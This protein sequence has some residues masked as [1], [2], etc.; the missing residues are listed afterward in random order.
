MKH[1]EI[2]G[3]KCISSTRLHTSRIF[4]SHDRPTQSMGSKGDFEYVVLV[5]DVGSGKS[6]VGEKLTGVEGRS[7]ASSTSFTTEMAVFQTRDG[8]LVVAD[9]PGSNAMRDKLSHN[10]EIASALNYADV[11][12]ILLVVKAETRIGQCNNFYV[13]IRV[14]S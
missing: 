13:F 10:T 7:S 6:T 12:R 2:H 8:G 1:D 11:S 14:A 9:T 4:A 5:G 3:F